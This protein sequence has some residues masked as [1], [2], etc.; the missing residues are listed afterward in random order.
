MIHRIT[1]SALFVLIMSVSGI[2]VLA[3]EAGGKIAG[4]IISGETQE[5]VAFANISLFD[6]ENKLITGT[7][8]DKN[9]KFSIRELTISKYRL[10]ISCLGYAKLKKEIQID[11]KA[12]H[13]KL[14]EIPLNH[15]AEQLGEVEVSAERMKG[16]QEVDRT[17]FNINEEVQNTA[18]DGIDILKHVPGVS[19]DFQDNITLDGSGNIMYL[20]NGVKRDKNY[21]AQLHPKDFNK[22]EIITNPG[23]EYEADV[24]AV[25]N[26]V[27]K[28][29][30]TGGR[31]NIS[32]QGSDPDNFLG[33]ES[34]SIQYGN[35]NFRFFI[36]DRLHY[37]N[38]PA[39]KVITNRFIHGSDTVATEMEG[40][41]RASWFNNSF[42]YGFDLFLNDKNIINLYGEYYIHQ[43]NNSNYLLHSIERFNSE[44]GS[45]YDL[46]Q[47]IISHNSRL[48]N[49][50]FY[51]HD[52]EHKEHYLSSQVN[53]YKYNS[54][55]DNRYEYEY[56]YINPE[57]NPDL[58]ESRSEKIRNERQRLEWKN[59]YSRTVGEFRLKTGALTYYQW[60]NNCYEMLLDSNQNFVY[61][62][63][64]Q[65]AY[66]SAK[67][68]NKLIQ[69]SGGVRMAYSKSL[70]DKDV[71]NS[72][73][74]W[75]PK[76][77]VQYNISKNSSLNFSARRR[78]NRPGLSQLN[79]F[80][81]TMDERVI[82]TGNPDLK[83][84]VLN[85]TE[86]KYAVN[87]NTSYLA[88]KIFLDYTTNS[89]QQDIILAGDGTAL[90]RPDNVGQRYEYGMG[91]NGAI[92]IGRWFRMNPS[93]SIYKAEVAGPENYQESHISYRING[94]LI[95][96]PFS[97]KFLS[98]IANLHY[99]GPRLGY[100][101]TY[102]R[103]PLWFAGV[104]CM[105]SK[106]F[107]ATAY[108]APV[109]GSF[110]Y[111]ETERRDGDYHYL[112]SNRIDT[113]WLIAVQ[114][115]Y[116]FKWGKTPRKLK[117]STDYEK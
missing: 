13:L 87:I 73:T 44:S 113:S 112:S 33:N 6:S 49:S 19:V 17:V 70:I 40:S 37:E 88:P 66:I 26:I 67:A 110:I 63:F 25:I 97:K 56:T 15:A 42:N 58:H 45:E 22:V 89:I 68:G 57:I 9:G 94:Q 43:T 52:F 20:V 34:A 107:K 39:S 114:I 2:I 106:N 69:Y 14:G 8:S 18:S 78:I 61:N 62:E 51:K 100:K 71:T 5:P 41:G 10:E 47:S 108:V 64:R 77:S 29:R 55:D 16:E 102:R 76:I 75:L 72:Y 4:T 46:M 91:F 116:G 32:L 83:P 36:S 54:S 30:Q 60:F 111:Q 1:L 12:A 109:G 92:V 79:P 103:D 59:D 101:S 24:D 86:L 7:L 27:T 65:E 85:R 117:R 3:Q 95:V 50:L 53:H 96:S 115:S 81:T 48:Y 90:M 105:F 104:N 98:F 35:E 11:E 80:I 93:L 23:V 84:E 82:H 38:F 99:H 74:E 21:V 28:G 31:G